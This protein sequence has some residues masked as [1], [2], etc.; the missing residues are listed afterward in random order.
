MTGATITM[1]LQRLSINCRSFFI[2]CKPRVTALIVFTAMIG[3]FLATPGMVPLD[4]LVAATVGI[5]LASG[6]AAAFNCLI[7]QKIDAL[8]AR[9][10]AR[11][12]PTGQV[13]SIQTA[14]FATV[15]G[16]IGLGILYWYINPLTMWLTFATFIGYAVIYTIFLKPATPLN[17]VIGGASGAMPPVL[18]WA[19][20][21]NTIAPEA[22]ILFLII[23]AWTP[24]HF[25]ALALY[26]RSEYAKSG[27]PMLPITHGEE[28][29]R[30]HILLYTVILVTVT[31]MPC[32][33]GMSGW[34]YLVSA[35]ALDGVFLW[36]AVQIYRAYSDDLAKRA[37]RY[38]IW[39]LM[40][41]F[42]ALL[43]DHYFRIPI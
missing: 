2:M 8:M 5:A 27:L 41:L 38:S 24:P 17:I 40:L 35:L 39:Y 31:L 25:W 18:G 21:T 19:A 12:L 11:P 6:A 16:S 9:T 13:G 3:M 14:I 22:L 10:R 7:E 36:Y 30:L 15:V 32:A 34:I 1:N 33:T 42:A 23:F 20:V 28:F 26:R 29:T 43:L 4:L 37:F